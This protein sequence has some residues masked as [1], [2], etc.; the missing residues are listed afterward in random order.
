MPRDIGNEVTRMTRLITLTGSTEWGL[1]PR[2]LCEDPDDWAYVHY[3]QFDG[4]DFRPHEIKGLH[5]HFF[6][7]QHNLDAFQGIF[8][9]RPDLKEYATQELYEKHPTKP[10]LWLI[11]GRADDIIVF[12]NAEKFNPGEF[13]TS[14]EFHPAVNS[15]VVAGQGKPQ[16]LLLVEPVK[17]LVRNLRSTGHSSDSSRSDSNLSMTFGHTRSVL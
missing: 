4:H 5:E 3:T 15:A 13:E 14:V 9:T 16:P 17:R 1:Y 2:I 8:Q 12:S 6:V 11:R 7:K 10:D